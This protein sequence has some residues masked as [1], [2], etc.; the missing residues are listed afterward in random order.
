MAYSLIVAGFYK[1]IT[2]LIEIYAA[3]SWIL[4]NA[5]KSV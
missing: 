2:R 5:L 1:A 3:E 4:T